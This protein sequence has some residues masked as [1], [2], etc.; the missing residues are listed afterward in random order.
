MPGRRRAEATPS[1]GRLSPGHDEIR[2]KF[3]SIGCLFE[4]GFRSDPAIF[5]SIA[6]NASLILSNGG[7]LV[8]KFVVA[9]VD[10]HRSVDFEHDEIA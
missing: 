2:G 1:F 7:R 10:Q 6:S 8:G 3:N 5:R 9:I 4:S